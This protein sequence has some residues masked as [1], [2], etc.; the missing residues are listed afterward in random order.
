MATEPLLGGL[1]RSITVLSRSINMF[2]SMH[3]TQVPSHTYIQ[4]PHVEHVATYC[5]L[6]MYTCKPAELTIASKLGVC[7]KHKI[8]AERAQRRS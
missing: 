8:V 2:A 1:Y 5:T 4:Y 6:H 3:V 7:S